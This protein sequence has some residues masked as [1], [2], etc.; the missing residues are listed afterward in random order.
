MTESVR[1]SDPETGLPLL[2]GGQTPPAEALSE[3]P[4]PPKESGELKEAM[5]NV[6]EAEDKAANLGLNVALVMYESQKAL[7]ALQ[8]A[9]EERARAIKRAIA[10]TGI[11]QEQV[12]GFD[13][14]RGMLKFVKK[15]N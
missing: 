5:K 8:K 9:T 10:S 2:G 3:Y 1:V 14:D 6:A 15:V 7:E 4:L 12:R 11:H 13:L